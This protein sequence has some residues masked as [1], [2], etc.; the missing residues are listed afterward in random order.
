MSQKLFLELRIQILTEKELSV[1]VRRV[2][3]GVQAYLI[4]FRGF[5]I[6]C[7]CGHPREI[8]SI[9]LPFPYSVPYFFI[10][11]SSRIFSG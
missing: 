4:S 9:L 2:K 11:L 5:S 1:Y 7:F 8:N 10:I 6:C 3:I